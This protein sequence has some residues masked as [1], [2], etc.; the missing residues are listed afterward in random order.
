MIKRK[1]KGSTNL[2]VPKVCRGTVVD[3]NYTNFRYKVKT[4][5]EKPNWFKL[6][7]SQHS[8]RTRK[9]FARK[10]R[11]VKQNADV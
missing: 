7:K 10:W 8:R 1:L 6:I 11:R 4:N 2:T 9:I 5:E 3:V